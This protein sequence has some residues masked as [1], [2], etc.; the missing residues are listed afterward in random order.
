MKLFTITVLSLSLSPV[1]INANDQKQVIEI[2]A[3]S[4]SGKTVKVT[5]PFKNHW[6]A[7]SW[8]AGS[9][10]NFW[11]ATKEKPVRKSNSADKTK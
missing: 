9:G 5:A 10:E 4:K 7:N 2:P 3:I 1:F 6:D 8:E 11:K